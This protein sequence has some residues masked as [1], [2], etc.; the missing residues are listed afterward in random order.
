MLNA[1]KSTI[2][3]KPQ[4]VFS[5]E[6]RSLFK[7]FVLLIIRIILFLQRYYTTYLYRL[8]NNNKHFFFIFGLAH[9]CCFQTI[10]Y[11]D[12]EKNERKKLCILG[13]LLK[14]RFCFCRHLSTSR[15]TRKRISSFIDWSKDDFRLCNAHFHYTHTH[16]LCK[17]I[18]SDNSF[19]FLFSTWQPILSLFL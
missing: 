16:S 1:T 15:L 18:S 14:N 4:N 2:Q 9:I 6:F 17:I 11:A 10:L 13:I 3:T 8:H 12:N 19:S 5:S 7:R